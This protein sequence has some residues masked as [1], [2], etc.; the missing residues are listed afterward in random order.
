MNQA[1][2]AHPI[3]QV[4]SVGFRNQETE[5]VQRERNEFCTGR[6]NRSKMDKQRGLS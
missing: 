5:G 2:V 1:P 3:G 6:F 4:Y